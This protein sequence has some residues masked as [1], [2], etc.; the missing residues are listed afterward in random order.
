MGCGW[1]GLPLAKSLLAKGYSVY[2]TTTSATNIPNL[3]ASGIKAFAV[4]ISADT[5]TGNI[6]GFLKELSILIVNIPPRLRGSLKENYVEKMQLLLD[7]IAPSE[8]QKLIFISSTS[9]YG[10]LEG[11]VTEATP[12][13]PTTASGKQL[14]QAEKL[15]TAAPLETSIVRFGGL[16][17]PARHPLT[18]LSLKKELSNGN[19][20]ILSLIHI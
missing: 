10:D 14:W 7:A 13:K 18:N 11:I 2:G 12:P 1:L 4:S 15:F 5:I 16:L 6:H 8:I 9:V 17:G 3:E 19:L 20:P